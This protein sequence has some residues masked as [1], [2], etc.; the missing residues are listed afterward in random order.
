MGRFMAVLY[1]DKK[2]ESVAIRG[3]Y[4]DETDG[5][6]FHCSVIL[7]VKMLVLLL[8]MLLMRLEYHKGTAA[9]RPDGFLYSPY[10]HTLSLLLL[11]HCG[12]ELLTKNEST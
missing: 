5:L 7:V 12:V 3:A 11:H 2:R 8:V 9:C 1:S 6:I 4:N 10:F